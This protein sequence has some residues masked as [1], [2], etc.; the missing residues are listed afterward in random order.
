MFVCEALGAVPGSLE[1]FTS[2]IM[3]LP[4]AETV[5]FPLSVPSASS[6]AWPRASTQQMNSLVECELLSSGGSL[7]TFPNVFTFFLKILFF[8]F[9]PKA[10]RYIVVYMFF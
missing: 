9:L 6:H 3:Q 7:G 10:P 8:L 2:V 4:R 1:L 5:S